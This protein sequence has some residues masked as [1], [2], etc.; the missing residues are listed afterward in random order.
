M[1]DFGLSISGEW[2]LAIN[3]CGLWV[4]GVGDGIRYEGTYT[5]EGNG[6]R[7]GSCDRWTNWEAYTDEMKKELREFMMASMDGMQVSARCFFFP[8]WVLRC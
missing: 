7:V 6:D 1:R 8:C 4:N 3:D 5:K 2:S